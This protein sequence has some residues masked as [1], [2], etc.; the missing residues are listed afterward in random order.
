M[1]HSF[2]AQGKN[3]Q[4]NQEENTEDSATTWELSKSK[5]FRWRPEWTV[6]EQQ[7]ASMRVFLSE[8]SG[9]GV[10]SEV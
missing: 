9:S 1:G 7:R 6:F 2:E 4:N 5:N 8:N 3:Q 10:V